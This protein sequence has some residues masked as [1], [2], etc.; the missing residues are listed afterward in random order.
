MCG[1]LLGTKAYKGKLVQVGFY[2]K[3]MCQVLFLTHPLVLFRFLSDCS[4]IVFCCFAL[5][6]ELIEAVPEYTHYLTLRYKGVWVDVV[7]EV[8]EHSGFAL[9]CNNQY[10]FRVL[11]AVIAV[12]IYRRATTMGWRFCNLLTYFFVSFR[13]NKE[14]NRP[15]ACIYN[16]V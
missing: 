15:P 3:R 9:A 7:D 6:L 1:S 14:L 8:V 16:L 11:S 10:H 2:K 5:Y 4:A 13:D 12:R